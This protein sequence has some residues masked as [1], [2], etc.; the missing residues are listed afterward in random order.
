MKEVIHKKL[1]TGISLVVQWV[2]LRAPNAGGP[3]SIPGWGTRFYMHA[4]TKS[5]HAATK[6]PCMLQLRP[7]T[8]KINKQIF[9]NQTTP[10]KS[11]KT[12]ILYDS[13]L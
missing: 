2:K 5:L 9:K 13:I 6:R 4:T 7:G 1:Y 10:P 8:A 3:S 12:H 11:P